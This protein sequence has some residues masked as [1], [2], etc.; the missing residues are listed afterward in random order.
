MSEKSLYGKQAQLR[1]ERSD[2]IKQIMRTPAIRELCLTKNQDGIAYHIHDALLRRVYFHFPA[3]KFKKIDDFLLDEFL[4]DPL[5]M[6]KELGP[7][8]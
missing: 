5:F 3:E 6:I 8:R 7:F 4:N 1:L 2:K